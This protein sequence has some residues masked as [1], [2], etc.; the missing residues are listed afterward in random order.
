M[1]DEDLTGGAGEGQAHRALLYYLSKQRWGACELDPPPLL[2]GKT[3]PAFRTK[4]LPHA[5][6][7]SKFI[8]RVL[9]SLPSGSLKYTYSY[10]QSTQV[11]ITIS[12]GSS[13][14]R[15]S[16]PASK[17]SQVFMLPLSLASIH[18]S[19]WS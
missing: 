10:C 6:T 1:G 4:A 7:T 14:H 15:A 9:V 17:P 13:T 11:I 16:I 3:R 5:G 8:H 2:P 19:R 12:S 18:K